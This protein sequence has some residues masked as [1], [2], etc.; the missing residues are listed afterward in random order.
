[1]HKKCIDHNIKVDYRI[2]II[3]GT[4]ILDT[5]CHQTVIQVSTSPSICFCTT[6]AKLKHMK[7][8]LK[9]TKKC[10]KPSVTL[11]IGTWR[12]ITRFLIVFGINISDI[13]GH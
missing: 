5:T 7:L 1:M 11:L 6:L 4:T 10:R 8:A 9:W 3:F 13:T 12:R 2:L